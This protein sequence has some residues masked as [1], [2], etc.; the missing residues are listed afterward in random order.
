MA[1]L[2]NTHRFEPPKDFLIQE[3]RL[4]ND[5]LH[6]TYNVWNNRETITIDIADLICETINESID[7][8]G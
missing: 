3:V 5:M 7:N 2:E 1:R 6:I 4:V 8:I